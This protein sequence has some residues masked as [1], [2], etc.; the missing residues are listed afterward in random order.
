MENG[1]VIPYVD[2]YIGSA[3]PEV[4]GTPE[5]HGGAYPPCSTLPRTYSCLSSLPRCGPTG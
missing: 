2:S 5:L 3:R 1:Q 4:R